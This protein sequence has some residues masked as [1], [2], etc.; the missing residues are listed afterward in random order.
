MRKKRFGIWQ[1]YNWKEVYQHVTWICFGFV[2][3]GLQK[4]DRVIIIGNNDPELFWVQWGIQCAGGIPVCLLVDSLPEE[5]K[6]FID[7]SGARF[8][9]GED[10]EQVDKILA[11][12]ENCPQIEKVIYWDE[13]GLWFYKEPVIISLSKLEQLGKDEQARSPARMDQCINETKGEDTAVIIYT[14]GTTGTP[15]GITIPYY[16]V[17]F[18]SR[19]S[20]RTYGIPPGSEY[21]SYAPPAWTEQTL[22]LSVGPDYP[23]VISFAEEPET[24]QNDIMEIS[25]HMLFYQPR[26]WEDLARQIRMKVDDSPWWK[27]LS[28]HLALKEGYRKLEAHEQGSTLPLL[29]KI[30]CWIAD[31]FVLTVATGHYG[32]KRVRLCTTSGTSCAPNLIRFFRALGVPLC[33]AYGIVEAGMIS[34]SKQLERKYNTVGQPFPGIE[35]KIEDNEIL[36]RSPGMAR[37]YWG[38]ADGLNKRMKEGWYH[39]GDTGYMDEDGY[40]VI[41]DRLNEMIRLRGGSS[42]SPQ[43]IEAYLRF[44]LYI[45]DAIVFGDENKSYLTAIVSIDFGMVSKWAESRNIPYTTFI[46]LSQKPEVLLL[47]AEEVKNVNKLLPEGGRIKKF[48]SLDK[49]FDPDE[50]ELT[51]SRKLKRHVM[52]KKYEDIYRFMYENRET[53]PVEANVTYSEG[54]E[55]KVSLILRIIEL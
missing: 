42:F 54:K 36:V 14:S 49:E 51:R 47:L 44:S 13:R 38:M 31:R 37:E 25:P 27:R 45:K 43:S 3:L 29:R 41:Y 11:I 8:F 33:S 20:F 26:L 9:I 6:Y 35:V 34:S 48:V 16:Y 28:F 2:F 1:Q 5:A 39:T 19:N 21:F 23:L 12:K 30:T 15:K 55:R 22:G 50:T 4:G 10:Q 24:L 46:E 18:Y 32:M 53:V 52:N 17:L 7:N 40:L